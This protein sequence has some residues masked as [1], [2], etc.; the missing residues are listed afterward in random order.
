MEVA[1]LLAELLDLA[2]LDVL[3]EQDGLEVLVQQVKAHVLYCTD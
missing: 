1:L 2:L 3:A